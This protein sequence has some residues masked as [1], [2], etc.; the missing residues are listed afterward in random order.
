MFLKVFRRLLPELNYEQF[1]KIYYLGIE[2]FQ[3]KVDRVDT[4]P[5]AIG[6]KICTEVRGAKKIR[7]PKFQL[8]RCYTTLRIAPTSSE[9]WIEIFTLIQTFFSFQVLE[10][11]AMAQKNI[12]T[13][14][15]HRKFSKESKFLT[16]LDLDYNGEPQFCF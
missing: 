3:V 11:L 7:F 10:K 15:F 16:H 6:L 8:S 12:Q 14:D 13:H 9:I 4:G 5:P 2:E 1:R